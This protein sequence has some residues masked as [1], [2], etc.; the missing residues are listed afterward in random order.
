MKGWRLSLPNLK[1]LIKLQHKITQIP[2]EKE[3]K[4]L[5]N[6]GLDL[7]LLFMVKIIQLLSIR[8]FSKNLLKLRLLCQK[9]LLFILELKNITLMEDLR[10]FK[11]IN[12]IGLPAKLW[13]S[14]V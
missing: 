7:N 8:N 14:T 11:P 13:L 3:Q 1:K 5:L 6:N 2:K 12:W 4:P 10:E 9:T